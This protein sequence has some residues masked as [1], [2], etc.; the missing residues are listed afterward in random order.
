M[1]R[2][3]MGLTCDSQNDSPPRPMPRRLSETNAA[4]ALA[5]FKQQSPPEPRPAPTSIIQQPPQIMNPNVGNGTSTGTGTRTSTTTGTATGTGAFRKKQRYTIKNAE[6]WGER[7]GRPA[8]YDPAGRALW[9]RPSDG[10]L[11]YL[12][13]PVPSCGKS[14]FVT[15]HGFMCH[16][17]KKHKDRSLGSQSRA[18]DVCGTVYD[19]NAPRPPRPSVNRGSTEDSRSGSIHTDVEGY[20]QEI[21]YSSASDEED[22]QNQGPKIKKE[23][24]GNSKAPEAHPDQPNNNHDAAPVESSPQ[25]NGSNKPTI[26]AMID[27]N[28]QPESWRNTTPPADV[29]GAPDQPAVAA[30]AANGSAESTAGSHDTGKENSG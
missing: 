16:L 1:K 2:E 17:T 18:L 23:E 5:F 25:T 22:G 15:L 30:A 8:A 11:V 29:K 13:C 24:S 4:T 19:P 28:V 20:Q 9:K 12:D 10:R 27:N 3:S 7:H 21:E 14:D 6:A 26:A